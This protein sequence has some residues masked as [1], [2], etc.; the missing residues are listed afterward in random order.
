MCWRQ[1]ST[2]EETHEPRKEPP[3][4]GGA[5]CRNLCAAAFA[6]RPYAAD[7]GRLRLQLLAEHRRASCGHWRYSCLAGGALQALGR[8]QRDAFPRAA[9]PVSWQAGVQ[10]VQRGDVLRAVAGDRTAGRAEEKRTRRV[11]AA[12]GARSSVFPD[13]VLWRRFSVAGRRVQLS[14]GHGAGACAAG[15]CAKRARRRLL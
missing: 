13:A 1:S 14:V 15:D 10:R 2:T 12:C 6:Q 3:D 4:D 5:V 9:V 11:A 8:T 7:D